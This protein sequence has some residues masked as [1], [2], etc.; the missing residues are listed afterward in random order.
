MHPLK[1]ASKEQLLNLTTSIHQLYGATSSIT[2]LN[3]AA[4]QVKQYA[5]QNSTVIVV[6]LSDGF[7][8][9]PLEDVQKSAKQVNLAKILL[10]TNLKSKIRVYA[11]I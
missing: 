5:R 9:D 7:G 8:Y 11:K 10:I 2:G 6:H 4:E 3:A 1:A